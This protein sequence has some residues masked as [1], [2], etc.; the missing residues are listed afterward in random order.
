MESVPAIRPALQSADR[1]SPN[2]LVRYE[3]LMSLSV[4]HDFYGATG[5]CSDFVV[6][7]TVST[8]ALMRNLGLIAKPRR[9]GIDILY[10][11]GRAA[12]MRRYLWNRR[13]DHQSGWSELDLPRM[14]TGS[15]A[16]L[17]L[18]FTLDNPLFTNFTEMPF[19]VQP[20][21]HTLYLS[22]RAVHPSDSP[23]SL[24]FDWR[25]AIPG[26]VITFSP[27][28]LRIPTSKHATRAVLYNTSG[29]AMLI[30]DLSHHP[31]ASSQTGP[32]ASQ[33]QIPRRI[34]LQPGHDINLD[35]TRES[36]GLYS[37]VITPDTGGQ[38][39]V[40]LYPGLR[41]APLLMVD[42][43]LDGPDE[44]HIP[45]SFPIDLSE[46]PAN[47]DNDAAQQHITPIEYEIRFKARET[48]WAYHV[49]LPEGLTVPNGLAI[50]A[51]SKRAPSF[52]PPIPTRLATG[53]PA[54]SFTA[55]TPWALQFRSDVSLCLR[56][57]GPPGNGSSRILLERLP[58]PSADAISLHPLVRGHARSDVF[59]YL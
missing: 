19:S 33:R 31:A 12:A 22:N 51:K 23:I 18:A 41:D 10:Y 13:K 16:R 21:G 39:K 44:A 7:P 55:I 48:I 50:E 37:Y 15:W 49:V 34:G 29:R 32:Q 54:Y 27:A 17:T 20:G 14:Q 11:N 1:P 56:E 42:L 25:Q 45:G 59:V 53:R 2:Q 24:A 47:E 9:D 5:A 57:A 40:F 8:Q 46:N 58:L 35:M 38:E 30:A 26:Q 4:R 28:H 6:V 3:R 36:A 52:T 43:F